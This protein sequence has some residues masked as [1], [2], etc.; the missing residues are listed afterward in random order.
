MSCVGVFCSFFSGTRRRGTVRE[1]S[2]WMKKHYE[3][4]CV[5][6]GLSAMGRSLLCGRYDPDC[7]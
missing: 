3:M 5:G 7:P 1:L 2:G 6:Q 4:V